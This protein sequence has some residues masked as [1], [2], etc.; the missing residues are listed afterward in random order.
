[1]IKI[2]QG[3]LQSR[4]I[5]NQDPIVGDVFQYDDMSGILVFSDEHRVIQF[6]ADGDVST[7][8]WDVVTNACAHRVNLTLLVR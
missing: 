2:E 4:E 5:K 8:S 7:F 3:N 6:D 1:M